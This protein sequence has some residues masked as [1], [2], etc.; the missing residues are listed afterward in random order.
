MWLC[1]NNGF[2]SV[3]EDRHDHNQLMVRARNPAHLRNIF[4][5]D[6]KITTT[7]LNDYR[8]RT[9]VTR[10]AL[11]DLIANNILAIDYGNFKNSVKDQRLLH[12]Y[13]NIWDDHKDYQEDTER[14]IK[15]K[16]DSLQNPA[17]RDKDKQERRTPS[18]PYPKPVLDIKKVKK[19]VE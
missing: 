18:L 4:G 10:Q 9:F 14:L 12:M 16:H 1:L 8:W 15:L 7:P 13:H 6:V 5:P 2:V 19:N 11:A 17:K 3:V